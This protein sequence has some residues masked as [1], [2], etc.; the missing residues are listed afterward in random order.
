MYI[1]VSRLFIMSTIEDTLLYLIFCL[2]SRFIC[3]KWK[4]RYRYEKSQRT[5]LE[6]VF[7][8][9]RYTPSHSLGCDCALHGS[10]QWRLHPIS[11][12]KPHLYSVILRRRNCS[13]STTKNWPRCYG[14]L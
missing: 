4:W 3:S 13:L 7:T 11:H 14:L 8:P 10:S 12:C 1:E 6:T 9:N 5:G 2:S